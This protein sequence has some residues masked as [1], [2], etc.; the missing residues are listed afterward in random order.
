MASSQLGLPDRRHAGQ[1]RPRHHR[2]HG[3]GARAVSCTRPG[4]GA[5]RHS[6]HEKHQTLRADSV[7]GFRMSAHTPELEHRALQAAAA[8]CRRRFDH[9]D[10]RLRP[11]QPAHRDH[12]GR[13]GTW[14]AS[15]TTVSRPSPAPSAAST[16]SPAGTSSAGCPS[17]A[18][19]L[20]FVFAKFVEQDRRTMELQSEGLRHNPHLMLID[21]ADRPA[22]WY[23]A[24]EGR[25]SRSQAHGRRDEASDGRAGDS[26]VA[27]LSSCGAGAP[28]ACRWQKL[29]TFWKHL[30]LRSPATPA[31]LP[32]S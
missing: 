25:A 31:L 6:I 32:A 12:P 3:P 17:G 11:A 28:P 24:L 19:L 2:P 7:G 27:K 15:L 21:D 30:F 5:R 14:F 20:K 26:K 1:R 23:F 10:H 16:W 8:L 13:E 29:F 22:K 18:S 9:H 4:G